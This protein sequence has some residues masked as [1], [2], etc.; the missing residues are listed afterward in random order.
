M[1]RFC[2]S[3]VTAL[4]MAADRIRV[5]ESDVMIAGGVESMSMVPMMGN[6]PSMSPHIFERD[7]KP[8]HRPTAWA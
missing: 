2:A 3:G 1:N 5:G 6:K 7:G 8:R 4:A